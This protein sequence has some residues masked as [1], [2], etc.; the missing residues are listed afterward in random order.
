[1]CGWAQLPLAHLEPG[2]EDSIG[3]RPNVGLQGS[4]EGRTGDTHRE[5]PCAAAAASCG[6]PGGCLSMQPVL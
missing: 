4:W 1:M 2:Q 5:G 6:E 3:Q